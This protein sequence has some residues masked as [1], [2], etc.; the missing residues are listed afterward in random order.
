MV[1]FESPRLTMRAIQM[2]FFLQI[3]CMLSSDGM[4][5]DAVQKK[6]GFCLIA[7]QLILQLLNITTAAFFSLLLVFHDL[8]GNHPSFLSRISISC[9]LLKIRY[10]VYEYRYCSTYQLKSIILY[11][12]PDRS[13]RVALDGTG[14][15]FILFW[16]SVWLCHVPLFI[17]STPLYHDTPTV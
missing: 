17:V 14:I 2:P 12:I 7:V 4:A 10:R 5:K 8:L 6:R 11:S 16:N 13:T 9:A 1:C 15:R 3:A